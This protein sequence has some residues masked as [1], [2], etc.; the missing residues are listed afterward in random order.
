MSYADKAA[1]VADE[2]FRSRVRSCSTE[3][4]LVFV[5]DARPEFSVLADL[6][7]RNQGSADALIPLVAGQPAIDTA[8]A[9]PDILA[10]VQSVWP[11]YGA[12]LVPEEPA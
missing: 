12:T 9:D 8:S 4:A 10:A 11:V 2:G 1:T 6:V 7:I 3:Q 5:N